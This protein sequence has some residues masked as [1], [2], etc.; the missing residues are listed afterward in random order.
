MSYE[1]L[2]YILW[3]LLCLPV[4]VIGFFCVSRLSANIRVSEAGNRRLSASEKK[5]L[6]EEQQKAEEAERLRR[7]KFDE[8]YKRSRGI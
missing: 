1:V 8:E 3:G 6:A 4:V 7:R 5:R 2:K